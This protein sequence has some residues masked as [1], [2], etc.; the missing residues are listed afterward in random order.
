MQ[1]VFATLDDL[2]KASS[3]R[4][5]SQGFKNKFEPEWPVLDLTFK[6]DI[7]WIPCIWQ[8]KKKTKQ[9]KTKQNKKLLRR[10]QQRPGNVRFMLA[11]YIYIM[12]RLGLTTGSIL[13]DYLKQYQFYSNLQP[14]RFY[15]QWVNPIF[16]RRT[17]PQQFVHKHTQSRCKL[18]DTLLPFTFIILYLASPPG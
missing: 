7:P 16:L 18:P 2:S 6:K 10:L 13:R 12:S 3:S 17:T 5:M 11:S 14:Y 15:K 4:R 1:M 8:K 9:N